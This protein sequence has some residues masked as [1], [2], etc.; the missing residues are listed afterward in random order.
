[1]HRVFKFGGENLTNG[2]KYLIDTYGDCKI[3]AYTIRSVFNRLKEGKYL[4]QIDKKLKILIKE[5]IEKR[6]NKIGYWDYI[7]IPNIYTD[8]KKSKSYDIKNFIQ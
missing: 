1:M 7:P 6:L 3:G 2:A 8:E 5:E 4:D